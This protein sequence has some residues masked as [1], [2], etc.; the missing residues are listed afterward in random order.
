MAKSRLIGSYPVIGIRPTIDGRRG[1]LDVRGSLEDQTMNMA[2][3]AAKLF[4]ENLRYSNGEPV[5]VVIADTT[6]GRVGE[7]AACADKFRKEGVD[8]TLTVTPCWC[9]GAETMDMDPQTIKAV[10]GFNGTERPGAVYLASVLATH[11]QKGLPAFGIY[12]HDVQD[13]NDTSIPADVAEKILRFARGAV[14]AGWMRNKA[15]VNI[16]AVTM[17]IAGSFC[18]ADVLQKYFGIRAEW[19]DEVEI[20]RRITIGIYDH[21]EYERALAWVKENCREGFDKNAGK[22]FPDV[23]TKSKVIAPDKD[24]EFIVKMTLIMRDL[25]LIHI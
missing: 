21:E 4:E 10:W 23:I 18:D 1:A 5:K 15:Y 17:G 3:S 6:I 7:S 13:A 12:G 8:I 14:A 16:G 24:W 22:N 25:S 11:A 2:K 20:L 9:Y 19:V